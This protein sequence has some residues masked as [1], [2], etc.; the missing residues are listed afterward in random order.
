MRK[1]PG[2]FHAV[3]GQR[4]VE[5]LHR[6]PDL[7]VGD[8]ERRGHDLEAEYPLCG[9][10]LHTRAGKRAQ[11]LVVEI[12]CDA[13]QDFSQ[14]RAGAAAGVEHIHVVGRETVGDVEIVL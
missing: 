10:L 13:A 6:Q 4:G 8:N 2:A 5:L 7:Q 3:V 12:G 14:I 1:T 11:P 9:G